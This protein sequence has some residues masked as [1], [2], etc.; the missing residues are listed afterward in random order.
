MGINAS[1]ESATAILKQHDDD[2]NG[3]L[4]LPEIK[5]LIETLLAPA[6]AAAGGAVTMHPD[7]IF[8]KFDAD[9]SGAIDLKELWNALAA[10]GVDSS[11]SNAQA[12]L[13][14]YDDDANGTPE[15]GTLVDKL[16]APAP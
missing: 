8:A 6:G 12:I 11:A 5:K 9:K 15:F 4:E 10:L 16:L 1:A 3:T 7:A 13:S 2:A 14:K